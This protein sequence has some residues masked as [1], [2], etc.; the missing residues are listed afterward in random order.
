MPT[1]ISLYAPNV[2]YGGRL[3]GIELPVLYLLL[4]VLF[5]ISPVLTSDLLVNIGTASKKDLIGSIDSQ[6]HSDADALGGYAQTKGR[7]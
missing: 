5:L 1:S 6:L 7:H 2:R 4:F 3:L